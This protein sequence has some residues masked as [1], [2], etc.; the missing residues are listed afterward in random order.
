MIFAYLK[1]LFGKQRDPLVGKL[2]LSISRCASCGASRVDGRGEVLERIPG[3][4]AYLLRPFALGTDCVRARS[5]HRVMGHEMSCF[6]FYESL[7][8]MN[9]DQ[10]ELERSGHKHELPEQVN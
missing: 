2:F 1:K 4:D 9:D 5:L 8:L 7:W 6:R 10:R 3:A